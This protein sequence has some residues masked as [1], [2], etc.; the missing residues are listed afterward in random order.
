MKTCANC[1]ALI[2]IPWRFK[3]ERDG[4]AY[5]CAHKGEYK[6]RVV[7]TDKHNLNRPAWCPK[8]GKS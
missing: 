3:G 6:G 4:K 7:S 2:E 8:E 5:R 1:P